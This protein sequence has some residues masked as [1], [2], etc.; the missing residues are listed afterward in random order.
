MHIDVKIVKPWLSVMSVS[1]LSALALNWFNSLTI[2]RWIRRG[3]PSITP[4]LLPPQQNNS[5]TATIAN[6]NTAMMSI[7]CPG[8]QADLVNISTCCNAA[9]SSPPSYLDTIS[10]LEYIMP[11]CNDGNCILITNQKNALHLQQ[12]NIASRSNPRGQV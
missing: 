8:P 9:N 5:Q 6:C 3:T 1:P 10:D 12:S 2:S 4:S 11:H 7:C